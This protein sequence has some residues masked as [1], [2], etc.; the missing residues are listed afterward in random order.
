[1]GWM[2]ERTPKT[3]LTDDVKLQSLTNNVSQFCHVPRPD[4]RLPFYFVLH[5]FLLEVDLYKKEIRKDKEGRGFLDIF[6]FHRHF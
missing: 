5:T 3:S 6:E 2:I 4:A 1:M